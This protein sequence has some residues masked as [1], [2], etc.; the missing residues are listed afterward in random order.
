MTFKH[1]NQVILLQL[2]P[3]PKVCHW[4]RWQTGD[5]FQISKS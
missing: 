1:Q 4:N 5:F 3:N 2:D